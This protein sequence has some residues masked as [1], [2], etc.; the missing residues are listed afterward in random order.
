MSSRAPKARNEPSS[1]E[2]ES[3]HGGD[4]FTASDSA[5][6]N[7]AA[8]VEQVV[9]AAPPPSPDKIER[10]VALLQAGGGVR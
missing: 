5:A 7:I 9:A 1:P 3:G 8:A 10:I 6:A 2:T 4:H